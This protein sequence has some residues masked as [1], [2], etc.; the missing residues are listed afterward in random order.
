M[1]NALNILPAS[2]NIIKNDFKKITDFELPDR[3]INF[4]T[5]N[6]MR[7]DSLFEKLS[8]F[9]FIQPK[10]FK[11]LC[12]IA[13]KW[14]HKNNDSEL[15]S[16]LNGYLL[17]IRRDFRGANNCFR[18]C[19]YSNSNNLDAW[20]DLA[21]SYRQLSRNDLFNAIVFNHDYLIYYFKYYDISK[22]SKKSFESTLLN[23]SFEIK[24]L[25]KNNL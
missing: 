17:Y 24:K 13:K 8:Y 5:D 23:I 6:I 18:N 11:I 9:Y 21:F 10:K 12:N 4:V 15:L 19:L 2:F 1:N 20:F 22:F 16:A 14:L 7:C 25:L 3:Q